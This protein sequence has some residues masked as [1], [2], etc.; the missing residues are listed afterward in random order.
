MISLAKRV[1]R[2]ILGDKRTLMLM[3]FAPLL[4]FTLIYL[5]LGDSAYKPTI[6]VN[7]D[8]LPKALVTALKEQDADIINVTDADSDPDSYLKENKEVDAL[9]TMSKS[10]SS[11]TMYEASSKSGE[12]MLAIRSALE[13]LNPAMKMDTRYIYGAENASTF[14]T[15]GYIFLGVISFFFIFIISGMALVRE[16]NSGTL[17]RMLMTPI[18]RKSIIYG[19]TMGYGLFAILQTVILV[20]FSLYVLGLNSEGNT[21]WVIS[22][23][24]LLAIAAVASGEFISI[25]ANSEFQVVQFIPIIIIP[26]IF[27]SGLIPLDTLPYHLGVLSYIMPIYYGCS[28]IKK[29][30]IYGSGLSGIWLFLL[31]LILYILLLSTFNTIVLKKYRRL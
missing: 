7:E 31:A 15:M 27:F 14:Q 8:K 24:L 11:I 9:F 23:M 18:K 3:I 17:E 26:Q 2:Q 5:L 12:A 29:V 19:Y 25:F 1:I 4:I 30:M 16:R 20:L 10:G 6:A 22:I 21:L 28:A 13:T